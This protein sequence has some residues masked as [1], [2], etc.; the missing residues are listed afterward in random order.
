MS[1][2]PVWSTEL[3]LGQPGLHKE[4]QTNKK[5]SFFFFGFSIIVLHFYLKQISFFVR[6]QC[7]LFGLKMDIM[8]KEPFMVVICGS[9]ILTRVR[10]QSL[11]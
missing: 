7:K 9:I 1:S 11:E 5:L 3:V 4:K 10:V 8:G 2:R 6:F